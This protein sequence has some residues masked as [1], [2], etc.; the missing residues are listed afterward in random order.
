MLWKWWTTF[1]C[2]LNSQESSIIDVY[3]VLK[4]LKRTAC[5]Q[6][7]RRFLVFQ[8]FLEPRGR[9]NPNIMAREMKVMTSSFLNR[10]NSE[11]SRSSRRR[12]YMK[13]V[14]FKK[15]VIFT[16]KHLCW[17][18]LKKKKTPT[19]IERYSNTGLAR[20]LY[21]NKRKQLL[22]CVSLNRCS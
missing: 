9:L 6:L 3:K 20:S 17:S 8:L 21:W 5:L 13:E 1:N 2:S 4:P 22:Q 12:C 15:F 7:L 18:L 16:G 14:V 11:I 10:K 19:L